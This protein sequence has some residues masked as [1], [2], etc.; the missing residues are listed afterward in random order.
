MDI[1]FTFD[2]LLLKEDK[3][4]IF[5]L[6]AYNGLGI[7]Y[8]KNNNFEKATLYFDKVFEKVFKYQIKTTE[9]TWRVLNIVYHCGEFYSRR[10]EW[11][12]SDELMRYAIGICSDNHVTYYLARASAILAE[13]AICKNEETTLILELI[14]DSIAYAKINR[15]Q[16]LL[17]KLK[18]MKSKY[19]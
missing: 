9:D 8:A 17:R 16:K 12:I 7:L 13:N 2:Q 18:I 4:E 15:N 19:S 3:N 14:Q 10:K 1:L 11:K 6:L 5:R